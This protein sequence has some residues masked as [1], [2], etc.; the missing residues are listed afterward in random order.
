MDMAGVERQGFLAWGDATADM[1]RTGRLWRLVWALAW[2]DI[3]LR[4]R[5][6]VIGPLWLSLSTALA[7]A[8]LGLLYPRLF[9]LPA[10]DYVPY[11]AVSLVLWNALV[12]LA[13]EAGGT[14]TQQEEVILS[15]ALPLSLH[16]ARVLARNVLAMAHQ[17]VVLVPVFVAFGSRPGEHAVMLAP[18]V[19]LW[20][21]DGFALAL[22]LGVLSA[23]FRDLPP[24]VAAGL[25]LAF[26]ATPV[27]WRA[28]QL[29]PDHGWLLCNPLHAMLD[30]LRAPLLGQVPSS[31]SWAV[32]VLASAV[33]VGAGLLVFAF[34]RPRLAFWL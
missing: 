34:A 1:R 32:G 33:L 21:L 19:A 30:I 31:A 17:A 6:S 8:L 4:Y 9:H 15:M 12:Q 29:G 2:M 13:T 23:R 10:A 11:L 5:G 14:F 25:Q 18:A 16:A 22:V 7:V 3:R 24:M 28:G 26:F 20:L 27:I